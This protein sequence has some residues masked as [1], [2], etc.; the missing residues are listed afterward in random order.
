MVRHRARET[1]LGRAAGT[2]PGC[3]E[4]HNSLNT[5]VQCP[6]PAAGARPDSPRFGN[7]GGC[8]RGASLP[9]PGLLGGKEPVL[10]PVN[11]RRTPLHVLA[12]PDRRRKLPALGH[13]FQG[14][15]RDR[16]A[17]VHRLLVHERGLGLGFHGLALK[18]METNVAMGRASLIWEPEKWVNRD[19]A[20]LYRPCPGT[21][22]Q[23]HRPGRTGYSDAQCIAWGEGRL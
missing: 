2:S 9:L 12:D 10:P 15:G 6:G 21:V 5:L 16:Q 11:C 7:G 13:V 3:R 18:W 4:M 23:E 14:A 22:G 20:D 19:R 17:L 8:P 1:L